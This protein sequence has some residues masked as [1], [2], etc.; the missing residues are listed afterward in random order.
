MTRPSSD[1][2][3]TIHDLTIGYPASAGTMGFSRDSISFT[4]GKGEMVAII[5]PNGIGK[6]TLLRTL[7]GIQKQL[8]G[9]T[10][11]YDRPVSQ[12]SRQELSK[13]LSFVST[14]NVSIVN[15]TVADLVAFGRF[16]HT[17]WIGKLNQNDLQVIHESIEKT[18][19]SGM[20]ERQMTQLS[21]GERQRVLIARA[22]AQDTPFI[23]L[24][25]PTAFLDIQ[26]KY[27][28]FRILHE[29]TGYLQKTVILS[30]HDL[31]I[32]LREVDKLWMLTFSETWEGAPEDA[33]LNGKLDHLF[34]SSK[35]EFDATEGDFRFNKVSV[36]T[37]TVVGNGIPLIWTKRA[38]DRKGFTIVNDDNSDLNIQITD[39]KFSGEVIWQVTNGNIIRTYHS[40]YELLRD[41]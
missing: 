6:S 1:K 5:G 19:L 13:T 18:G 37:A 40:L 8:A 7:C 29:L 12:I 22:L 16:P 3:L 36:G 14:E 39:D 4:A 25:E 17:N 21:D 31:N 24:D 35:M 28:V 34:T 10:L 26:N 11:L 9:E 38:L 20:A 30:T 2:A 23:I 33:V 27:S 15:M 41:I 32:A